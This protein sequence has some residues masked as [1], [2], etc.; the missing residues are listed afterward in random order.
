MLDLGGV[1]GEGRE[2]Q[3]DF[4]AI[5]IPFA[6]MYNVLV[7]YTAIR[8]SDFQRTQR[9]CPPELCKGSRVKE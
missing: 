3:A 2:V 1:K 6:Y 5:L 8:P 9:P 4:R 7:V